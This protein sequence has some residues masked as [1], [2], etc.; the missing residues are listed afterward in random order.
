MDIIIMILVGIIVGLG[1]SYW[2]VSFTK[3]N[4]LV[5]VIIAILGSFIGNT[6]LDSNSSFIGLIFTSIIGSFSLTILLLFLIKTT[7]DIVTN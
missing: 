3:I 6:I 5:S 4:I 1:L 7:R 2:L